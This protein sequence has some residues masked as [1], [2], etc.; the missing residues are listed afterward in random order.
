MTP[1]VELIQMR[2]ISEPGTASVPEVSLSIVSFSTKD[3][4]RACLQSVTEL[5]NADRVETIVV[6]NASTDGSAEMV[7]REFP[8]VRLIRNSTNRYFAPAHNQA[9]AVARGRYVASLNSDTRLYPDTVR[10]M[11]EFMDA[12]PDAGASTCAYLRDDGTLL[13]PEAHNYWRLHSLMYVALCRSNA[14]ARVYRLLGGRQSEP[15][16][17]YGDVVETDVVSGTFVFVPQRVLK[18]IGG[19][20]ERLLMYSTEDDLCTRVKQ[21]GFRIYY[22]SGARLVHAVSASVR[23]RS[24]YWMR[25][26]FA[27]DSMRYF[28]KH[29]DT[30]TRWLAVPV[31]FGAYLMDASVI[32]LRL[33]KWR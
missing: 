9:F 18:Q 26:I 24:P 33:G 23:R 25:W 14:G 28:L 27:A 4:L 31:L 20:D 3:L 21:C 17:T 16:R 19:Y 12:R 7:A 29:G 8:W 22:Y 5:E 10:K 2:P 15:I 11:V 32:T 6:D 13:N 30:L 1:S